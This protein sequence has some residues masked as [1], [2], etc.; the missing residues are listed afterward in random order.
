MP[1]NQ[2]KNTSQFVYQMFK[3]LLSLSPPGQRGWME[4]PARAKL[5]RLGTASRAVAELGKHPA[6][7]APGNSIWLWRQTGVWRKAPQAQQDRVRGQNVQGCLPLPKI[8]S[9]TAPGPSG[10]SAGPKQGRTGSAQ[11][12]GLCIPWDVQG[13]PPWLC[14][15]C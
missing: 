8:P 15:E 2:R 13:F 5:G 14:W 6:N 7:P 1:I 12:P 10:G 9:Q 3:V 11:L 4:I